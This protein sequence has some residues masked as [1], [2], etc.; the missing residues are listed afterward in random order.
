MNIIEPYAVTDLML[1]SSNIE[2]EDL[3]TWS[4]STTYAGGVRVIRGSG[5]YEAI[6]GE[7]TNHPPETD[8][9]ATWWLRMGAT[10]KFRPFDMRLG[11]KAIGGP[12]MTFRIAVPRT[13]NAVC[14]FGLNATS[15]RI[16]VRNAA[17]AVMLDRLIALASRESVGNA[18]EYVFNPFTYKTDLIVRGLKIPSGSTVEIRIEGGSYTELGEFFVGNDINLGTT[19]TESSLGVQDFSKKD[20]DEW[21]GVFIVPRSTIKTAT[22]RFMLPTEGVRRVQQVIQRIASKVCVFYTIDGEDRFGMTV[23]GILRDYDVTLS[24]G[25]SEGT[26]QAES[27]T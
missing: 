1:V 15:V 24:T 10:N 13:L 22:F 6:Q 23:A 17:D 12:L 19:L 9:Q 21:G 8:A 11:G 3:P 2:N 16:I 7:N 27:L 4:S 14:F 20:R 26:I 18:W 25:T 5:I